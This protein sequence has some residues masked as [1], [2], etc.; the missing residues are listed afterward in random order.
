MNLRESI[1][2]RRPA[3]FDV[4][5]MVLV[6][7]EPVGWGFPPRQIRVVG[8]ATDLSEA[9]LQPA[10][11]VG[12]AAHSAFQEIGRASWGNTSEWQAG[13]WRVPSGRRLISGL[14]RSQLCAPAASGKTVICRRVSS[15]TPL[16]CRPHDRQ[17]IEPWPEG[18]SWSAS[19]TGQDECS[20]RFGH[21][22][23][24]A[25]SPMES[26]CA[27]TRLLCA[28]WLAGNSAASLRACR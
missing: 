28:A 6:V 26:N 3:S 17:R 27:P 19:Q 13:R 5:T 24:R 23:G 12:F 14:S 25:S 20:T 11:P 10:R 16:K 22:D 7:G 4:G 15:I 9:T 21:G 1:V 2:F 8:E 18:P